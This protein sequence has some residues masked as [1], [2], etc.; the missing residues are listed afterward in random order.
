MV[1]GWQNWGHQ[2]QHQ[3]QVKTKHYFLCHR[4]QDKN[5]VQILLPK[6]KDTYKVALVSKE[7]S[8]LGTP[9]VENAR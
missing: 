6:T 2:L 1:F 5:N 4:H 3:H 9:S 7:S 8:F